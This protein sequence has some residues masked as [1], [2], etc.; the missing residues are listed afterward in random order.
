M[1]M[2]V[3]GKLTS[4]R[5]IISYGGCNG[6][7]LITWRV[8]YFRHI[9]KIW[10]MGPLNSHEGQLVMSNRDWEQLQCEAF[11]QLW[12][13]IVRK[14]G[15]HWWQEWKN[16]LLILTGVV[17]VHGHFLVDGV[18]LGSGCWR[19]LC[20]LH[21]WVHVDNKG[22]GILMPAQWSTSSVQALRGTV[23]G[24]AD[25]QGWNLKGPTR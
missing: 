2:E 12:C 6:Q 8:E 25:G 13:W 1:I 7:P 19:C 3:N 15:Y 22:G 16:M 20:L 18:G 4:L 11:A 5:K 17:Q 10:V 9:M 21:S 23:V 24:F 14:F